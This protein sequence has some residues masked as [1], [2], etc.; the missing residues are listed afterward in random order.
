MTLF[1]AGGEFGVVLPREK[2]ENELVWARSSSLKFSFARDVSVGDRLV[3]LSDA[4][5]RYSGS[6]MV[7]K[8]S[9]SK[10]AE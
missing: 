2:L 3:A 8:G 6:T 1:P 5:V 4:E 10:G 7:G 9:I